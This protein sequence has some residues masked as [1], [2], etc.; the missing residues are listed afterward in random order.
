MTATTTTRAAMTA[1]TMPPMIGPMVSEESGSLGGRGGRV[2][3]GGVEVG[4]GGVEV[5][6]GGDGN[7]F[8]KK[9]IVA[10]EGTD[11]EP[12]VTDDEVGHDSM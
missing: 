4:G 3:V 12:T 10:E 7:S 6:G 1:I 5:G 9:G 8:V 11:L 2:E